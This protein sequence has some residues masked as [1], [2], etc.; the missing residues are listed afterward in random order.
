MPAAKKAPEAAPMVIDAEM[1]QLEAV[2]RSRVAM[3]L[4]SMKL[5]LL[6]AQAREAH[7]MGV[8]ARLNAELAQAQE[9]AKKPAE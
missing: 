4:G 5:S 1:Q 9:Q 2:I 8:N 3:E 7:L 6:E